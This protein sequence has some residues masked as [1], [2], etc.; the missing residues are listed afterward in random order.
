MSDFDAVLFDLD[1]TLCRGDQSGET[2]YRGAFEAA[3][4]EPFGRPDELWASLDGPPTPNDEATYLARGFAAVAD[5]HGHTVDADA[6]ADGFLATVDNTAVSVL[7]GAPAALSSAR[8]NGPV[9]L[10]TN[11]PE[12]RQATKLTALDLGDAFDAVVFAGDLPRRKPHREPFDRALDALGVDPVAALHVGDSFE[13]DVAGARAAGLR[14]AWYVGGTDGDGDGR[15]DPDD[16][17]PDYVLRHLND[18]GDALGVGGP[19]G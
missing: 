3:G 17:R 16:D 9:G 13:Y 2:L 4:V 5:H 11:G 1:G 12:H 18:L 19:D 8:E 10:V 15:P 6:L 7:P 14:A